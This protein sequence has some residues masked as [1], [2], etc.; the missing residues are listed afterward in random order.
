MW[1]RAGQHAKI[2]GTGANCAS[3]EFECAAIHVY[4]ISGASSSAVDVATLAA[5]EA[6]RTFSSAQPP[7]AVLMIATC[8]GT[9]DSTSI[10]VNGVAMTL[11][12]YT[13]ADGE[14]KDT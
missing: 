6:T 11:G 1:Q 4:E 13:E 5:G 2:V 12:S 10:E 14:H 9:G 3:P 7:E 8:N